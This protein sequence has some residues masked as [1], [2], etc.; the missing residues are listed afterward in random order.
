MNKEENSYKEALE[1]Y[2][3]EKINRYNDVKKALTRLLK[4]K[5]C[6]SKEGN[7]LSLASHTDGHSLEIYNEEEGNTDSVSVIALTLDGN[8]N[9]MV[10]VNEID[11]HDIDMEI[12][13]DK[14]SVDDAMEMLDRLDFLYDG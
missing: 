14:I 10:V 9:I 12:P 6:Y 2:E 11:E 3:R 7:S 8:D 4:S 13:L 5:G 1:A